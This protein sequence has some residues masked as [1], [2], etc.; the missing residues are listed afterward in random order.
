MRGMALEPV[1]IGFSGDAIWRV[2]DAFYLKRYTDAARFARE[3]DSALWLRGRLPVPEVVCAI[4]DG[5]YFW[6]LNTALEGQMSFLPPFGET[7]ADLSVR[8]LAEG[9]EMI[10]AVD[11][12]ECPFDQRLDVKL[13]EARRN[14]ESGRVTMEHWE[15]ETEFSSP[16]ALLEWLERNRPD[17]V[18]RF[19]HGDYCMPNIYVGGTP[20]RVTGFVDLGL[21]GVADEWCDLALCART[22]GYNRVD[23]DGR[24]DELFRLLG[25][26]RDEEKL[27]YFVLLDE[28]F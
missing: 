16:E 19:S 20:P 27:R 2:G 4:E 17:E 7:N 11:I 26:K 18:L 8:L 3:R 28:L 13:A 5:G 25:I 21:C 22:M 15:E 1:T 24:T 12:S 10:R 9:L 23:G 14:V 6:L